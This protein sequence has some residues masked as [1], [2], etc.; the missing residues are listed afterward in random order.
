MAFDVIGARKEGYS[1][2]E[3]AEFLA[4]DQKFDLT[5]ARKEGYSDTEIID[6]LTKPQKPKKDTDFLEKARLIAA[7]GMAGNPLSVV[8]YADSGESE[9]NQADYLERNPQVMKDAA[10]REA[11]I[12]ALREEGKKKEAIWKDTRMGM[13]KQIDEMPDWYN[14]EGV[15]NKGLGLAATVGG[16]LGSSAS[17]PTTLLNPLRGAT[18]LATAAKNALFGAGLNAGQDVLQQRQDI[19][20]GI[21]Q[22]GYSPTTTAGSAAIGGL[23]G[24]GIGYLTHRT[25][26]SPALAEP[27]KPQTQWD[28][29]RAMN[30]G[31]AN[32]TDVEL[33]TMLDNAE[34]SRTQAMTEKESG[35]LFSPEELSADV[36][37]RSEEH[38]RLTAE[39]ELKSSLE[40][41]EF[42]QRAETGTPDMF[43]QKTGLEPG[44]LDRRI[45]G[46]NTPVEAPPVKG[47]ETGKPVEQGPEPK[48]IALASEI[49]F[50]TIPYRNVVTEAY[51]SRA[52]D[53][54]DSVAQSPHLSG[55]FHQVDSMVSRI[56]EYVGNAALG[57]TTARG[58]QTHLN[59]VFDEII[60]N[61]KTFAGNE[62]A[63]IVEE[64][65]NTLNTRWTDVLAKADEFAKAQN[66]S[67]VGMTPEKKAFLQQWTKDMWENGLRTLPIQKTERPNLR[68]ARD[69]P[70]SKHDIIPSEG[71]ASD[72]AKAKDRFARYHTNDYVDELVLKQITV[73]T[74][75]PVRD[76][77]SLIMKKAEGT[78]G[79][80]AEA[81]LSA[82]RNEQAYV[83]FGKRPKNPKSIEQ[84]N[85]D[86][87]G[88]DTAMAQYFATS[89][90]VQIAHPWNVAHLA[91]H[92]IGHHITLGH[93]TRYLD[94]KKVD[95]R[96]VAEG[97]K[98]WAVDNLNEGHEQKFRS[99]Q[100][101]DDI[102]TALLG[103]RKKNPGDAAILDYYYAFKNLKE[104]A[105][106]LAANPMFQTWLNTIPTKEL[107]LPK[108]KG[109]V[110]TPRFWLLEEIWAQLK[111]IW[112]P[113]GKVPESVW[114]ASSRDLLNMFEDV[115]K[116]DQSYFVAHPSHTVPPISVDLPPQFKH[117]EGFLNVPPSPLKPAVEAMQSLKPKTPV[118]KIV[119]LFT[120]DL[121]SYVDKV[122][123][124]EGLKDVSGNPFLDALRRL[125]A[126]GKMMSWI[127]EH[128]ALKWQIDIAY[129]AKK[130]VESRAQQI[131]RDPENG[132]VSK[133]EKLTGK[134]QGELAMI[135]KEGKRNKHTFTADELSNRGLNN[136]QID[137]Y[138]NS[139]KLLDQ[140]FTE[141]NAERVAKGRKPVPPVEGYWPSRWQGN[142]ELIV[143]APDEIAADGTK[144]PGKILRVD[145][146]NNKYKLEA[147]ADKLRKSGQYSVGDVEARPRGSETTDSFGLYNHLADI[148][149][150]ETP[151]GVALK[152]A[153]DTYAGELADEQGKLWKRHFEPSSG[154]EGWLGDSFH[155][156][157]KKDAT[158]LLH[159]V[160]GYIKD[161]LDWKYGSHA[162]RE[163]GAFWADAPRLGLKNVAE[164]G[165]RYWDKVNN[166]QGQVA[167]T[168]DRIIEWG[169]EALGYDRNALKTLGIDVKREATLLFLAYFKPIFIF[170]QGIQPHQFVGPLIRM[171]EGRSGRKSK[172]SVIELGMYG[173]KAAYQALTRHF[174]GPEGANLQA[175]MQ[176]LRDNRIVDPHFMETAHDLF[177]GKRSEIFR[178]IKGESAI[179]FAERY[180][181]TNAFLQYDKW[182]RETHPEMSRTTRFDTAAE[183][184][185]QS[186][187]N[188][189]RM[190]RAQIFHDLGFVGDMASG[191]MTFQINLASQLVFYMKEALKQ[192]NPKPL[193]TLL[194]IQAVLAGAMGMPFREELDRL[195]NQAK[196]K[197]WLPPTVRTPTEFL[198]EN[199][200]RIDNK[201]GA[202]GLRY[203]A[204]SG[205]SG[206]DI[207]PTFSA[208]GMIPKGGGSWLPPVLKKG[209]DIASA[210][211]DVG[212]ELLK[213]RLGMGQGPTKAEWGTLGKA[214]LPS[215]MQGVVERLMQDPQTGIVGDPKRNMEGTVT[216]ST[217]L[218]TV[219]WWSRALGSKTTDESNQMHARMA[220]RDRQAAL[221]P[222][223]AEFLD[224][225]KAKQVAGR[226]WTPELEA[227]MAGGGDPSTFINQVLATQVN[228]HVD[229][230]TRDAMKLKSR[231][232]IER[233]QRLQSMY[234]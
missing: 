166:K 64:L 95:A 12:K 45:P 2:T 161:G 136:R 162:S 135:V 57:D 40:S 191:L 53:V 17:D 132:I 206:V 78:R 152:Q 198:L 28:Q 156:N 196:A 181:R 99:I 92:E 107:N 127:E 65:R 187:T 149:G 216:R 83:T 174:D 207:S 3:I 75:T 74:S 79:L 68:M 76:V 157:P 225:A 24:G 61:V 29:I 192:R 120:P 208:G 176:Y 224:K 51:L 90:E 170:A 59:R 134:E 126:G 97:N 35:E 118:S 218:N 178:H 10:E 55:L 38:A 125:Y 13:R 58:V 46:D 215:S 84:L 123:S 80:I 213:E 124:F 1:D 140:F 87:E 31:L 138:L 73:K 22:G 172:S 122:A 205:A 179:A 7:E 23:L 30:P 72:A 169:P 93:I 47:Y 60:T 8:N 113:T 62:R 182:L 25:P 14:E 184:A 177:S 146:A 105:V 100:R 194:A 19:D 115:S 155:P 44:P 42:N 70:T 147:I 197:G 130:N 104:F 101:L 108:Q 185:E 195:M 175:A 66:A 165:K 219:D 67:Y 33:A 137:A 21:Q 160:E 153:M 234:K 221:G 139:R 54:V 117:L 200:H 223:Q 199:S 6:H 143:R 164:L 229:A 193:V 34:R 188:Y 154:V 201:R 82:L 209:V 102:Y 15:V 49:P 26:A 212:S 171:M 173:H 148:I 111:N 5:G 56:G 20:K 163:L 232:S 119:E 63:K 214:A 230:K 226:D 11:K 88:K 52:G 86:P 202:D 227:Y 222:R 71:P 203:G 220:E 116:F 186:M 96:A 151:E 167:E 128:P 89:G 91:L 233:Y 133:W 159:S 16:M 50:E 150:R 36:R 180:A 183:L 217:D 158:D 85:A 142:W 228:V 106:E 4:K 48:P 129:N 190:E 9:Q 168:I 114:I 32:K 210:G 131:L 69:V 145:R 18:K 41:Q 110:R 37:A 43:G 27:P 121:A 144:I 94:A 77:L 39:S 141:M 204:F 103:Y 231:A 211:A 112:D 109:P 98:A 81:M 189:R